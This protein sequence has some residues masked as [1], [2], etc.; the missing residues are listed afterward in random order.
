MQE[1]EIE[2]LGVKEEAS[3]VRQT[4][5]VV[6]KEH[7][8]APIDTSV[9]EEDE[10]ERLNL[11]RQSK[12]VPVDKING[13]NIKIF[14]VGSVGSHVAKVLCKTG[15]KNIEVY[16]MDTVENENIA[17]QAFDFKHIKT[18]KVDAIKDICKEASGVEIVTNHGEITEGTMISPE[19]NTIYCCYFDSLKARKMVF[20]K[21]KGFPVIWSD[22]RIG[23]FDMRHYLVNF[24]NDEEVEEYGK[25]LESTGISELICGE[26]ASAPINAQ[27]AGMIVMN[28][29]N[30]ISGISY[31]RKFIGNACEPRNNI[32]VMKEVKKDI[33]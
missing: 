25:S 20:E 7:E 5:P 19:P 16:D 8:L 23:R 4:E 13:W 33:V 30:Y 3:D 14:G 17:A 18:N 27:I 28:L 29:V 26:K 31:V 11:S 22:A 12:L 21:L 6:A 1:K 10:S 2:K 24:D 9:D 32:I 15:F